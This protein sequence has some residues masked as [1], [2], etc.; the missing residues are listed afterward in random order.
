MAAG[1]QMNSKEL[2]SILGLSSSLNTHHDSQIIK[3][4]YRKALL[5]H[6]P[7]KATPGSHSASGETRLDVRPTIDDITLAYKILS[8]PRSRTEYDRQ[9]A[10]QSSTTLQRQE[11]EV[12][13]SGLETVDLDDLEYDEA[14]NVWTRGC[15]CEQE[16][17]FIVTEQELEKEAESGELYVGCKGCSL[18]LRVLF[19][20]NAEE[21][22]N[23][24]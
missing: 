4:A 19:A 13:H 23:D 11:Q 17:A 6:H 8:N 5:A 18:W 12:F 7:D 15:R 16:Q 14:I 3:N 24:G 2:Y 22:T 1:F 10:L 9:I 20:A 21:A